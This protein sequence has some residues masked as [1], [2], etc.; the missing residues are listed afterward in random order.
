MVFGVRS[1]PKTTKT[2][3]LSPTP[4]Q[5]RNG[6]INSM[7]RWK[8]DLI[9]LLVAAVWG[10]GF[11]AQRLAAA[12]LGTFYFNGGRFLLAA[13]LLLPLTRLR[14]RGATNRLPWMAQRSRG[15]R[16]A[17]PRGSRR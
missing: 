17:V 8:S 11:V 9:L 13:L 1:T 6:F 16:S 10:S 12:S 4:E 3:S 14:W 15:Q 2:R 7:T 5:L